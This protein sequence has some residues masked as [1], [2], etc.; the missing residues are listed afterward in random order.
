MDSGTLN[1]PF[2]APLISVLLNAASEPV[3]TGTS[4]NLTSAVIDILSRIFGGG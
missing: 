4:S 1:K 3:T 2:T